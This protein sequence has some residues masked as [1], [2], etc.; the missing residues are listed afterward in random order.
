[1]SDVE[2]YIESS[3][4][5][6]TKQGP[7]S[8][9]QIVSLYQEG[10][11]LAHFKVTTARMGTDWVSVS[12]LVQA[13]RDMNQQQKEKQSV[14]STLG[15]GGNFAAP[16]RPTEQLEASRLITLNPKEA[17]GDAPDPTESLFQALQAV[18]E[19]SAQRQTQA[20]AQTTERL[21]ELSRE[22]SKIPPQIIL[23]V[24][25]VAVAGITLWGSL[26]LLK[27][28]SANV[29]S[30]PAIQAP[31]PETTAKPKPAPKQGSSL[32]STGTSPLKP[33][34]PYSN[35]NYN[36]QPGGGAQRVEDEEP[37]ENTLPTEV[38]EDNRINVNDA[39]IQPEPQLGNPQLNN[40]PYNDDR[41]LQ[42][43][44]D[45]ARPIPNAPPQPGLPAPSPDYP[46]APEAPTN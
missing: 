44:P 18:R 29:T 35:A 42:D 32:L 22:Q 2:W 10:K 24:V 19:K 3:A 13:Y 12:D 36:P 8:A 23:I 9:K 26:K 33:S 16:P 40:P 28:D 5:S 21:G 4:G 7:Y 39:V 11:V 31:A 37:N 46:V 25:I 38:P 34:Q 1:M 17:L 45:N 15:A 41:N 20:P 30:A 27:K 14:T 43:S 6:Q